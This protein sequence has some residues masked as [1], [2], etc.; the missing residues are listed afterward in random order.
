MIA[1][2]K[3]CTLAGVEAIPISVEVYM[4]EGQL[5]GISTVGLPDAAVRESKDR[6]CA[7]LTTS[8]YTIPLHRITINLAPANIRKEGSAF[9]LPI[10]LGLLRAMGVIREFDQE[11]TVVVGEL[12]LDGG[13]RPVRGVLPIATSAHENGWKR[14]IVPIE[15][16]CE[17][18]VVEQIEVYGV[19][20]LQEVINFLNNDVPLLPT[21]MKT[22]QNSLQMS[23]HNLDMSDVKGQ[24]YAKRALEIAAA[25]GHNILMIGPPGSGKTMLARRISTILP[26][27]SQNESLEV[28]KIHSISGL[29]SNHQG[30]VEN[31]PFRSP[32][33]S[34][35]D[36]GLIGGGSYPMPGEVSL[37]HHGVLFLDELPEFKRHVLEVMRQ[38]LEDGQVTIA[39]SQM[40]LTYPSRF[41]LVAAMNPCPCGF[42]SHPEKSCKCSPLQIDRYLG[43]IS[44]PLLDRI[45]LHLEVAAVKFK[46]LTQNRQSE[47]SELIR[48]RVENARKIQLRRFGVQSDLG[49]LDFKSNCG[50]KFVYNNSQMSHRDLCS[51]CKLDTSC[52]Q[53]MEQAMK[54]LGMSA[55]GFDRILKV[56]RTI[57]DLDESASIHA[58]HLAEAIQYRSLDRNNVCVASCA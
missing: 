44:G 58:Q 31:R 39:R 13:I 9:D 40:T 56:A 26:A 8:G 54:R 14:M 22:S 23:Y 12:A 36:A 33:H 16:A 47:S 25:G 52:V 42:R 5:P 18:S 37:A 35:S 7:A 41:M 48:S 3:T 30:L 17:A 55:R 50:S 43:R 2:I 20:N 34:I 46:D 21:R 51:F 24:E 10:A 45:D 29:L 6:V 32:H 38:P 1:R 27:M 53:L 4:R 49:R 15:N 11:S 19:R 57:G 28:T